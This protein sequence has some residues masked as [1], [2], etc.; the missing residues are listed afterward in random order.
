M[1]SYLINYIIIKML[2][3]ATLFVLSAYFLFFFFSIPY[4]EQILGLT[5][6]LLMILI[7]LFRF[8]FNIAKKRLLSGEILP[9]IFYITW[10]FLYPHPEF[11][12]T[13]PLAISFVGKIYLLTSHPSKLEVDAVEDL[14]LLESKV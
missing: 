14:I 2:L 5:L 11:I 6:N 8:G 4:F 7:I 13:L 3:S 12:Y 10:L 1:F 9:S